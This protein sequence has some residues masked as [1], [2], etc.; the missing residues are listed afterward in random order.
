[1]RL[2]RHGL[3]KEVTHCGKGEAAATVGPPMK[4]PIYTYSLAIA[5]S[6]VTLLSAI[7]PADARVQVTEYH[8]HA[9]RDGLYIDSAFTPA[10]AASLTRD[11][12]FDGTI[13][14]QVY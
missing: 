13:S 1:G 5:G 7:R 9:S 14:G 2:C 4:S 11:L 12:N 3:D 8:N 10:A 6:C